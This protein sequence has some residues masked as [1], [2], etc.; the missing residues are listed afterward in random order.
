MIAQLNGHAAARGCYQ[1]RPGIVAFVLRFRAVGSDS[2]A[3]HPSRDCDGRP[4]VDLILGRDVWAMAPD[5]A[6]AF[7]VALRHALSQGHYPTEARDLRRVAR[8]V[9]GAVRAAVRQGGGR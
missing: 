6:S 2:L 3:C 8:R 4:A 7:A 5:A 9:L 1:G